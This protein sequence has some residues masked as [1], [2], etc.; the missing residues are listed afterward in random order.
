MQTRDVR[1]SHAGEGEL[2][3]AAA[4]HGRG[5]Q[6]LAMQSGSLGDLGLMAGLLG[7]DFVACKRAGPDL[8][9]GSKKGPK[10]ALNGWNWALG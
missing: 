6:Q 4:T 8:L 3:C 5:K 1:G 2:G 10:W 7:P 9:L